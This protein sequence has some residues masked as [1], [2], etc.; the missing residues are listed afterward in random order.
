MSEDCANPLLLVWI[1][2]WLEQARER[3]SKGVTV[4]ECLIV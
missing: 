3:N 2:E 1:K 4:F